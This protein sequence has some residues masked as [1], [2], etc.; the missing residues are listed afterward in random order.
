MTVIGSAVAPGV[1]ACEIVTGIVATVPSAIAGVTVFELTTT[2]MCVGPQ[3]IAKP[4]ATHAG[5][6]TGAAIVKPLGGVMVNCRAAIFVPADP[7]KLTVRVAAPPVP[8]DVGPVSVTTGAACATATQV[9]KT[10]H[11]NRDHI[12]A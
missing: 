2:Q 9:R 3:M 8:T 4:A 7:D 11:L 10:G 12:A 5:V 6:R 1:Q